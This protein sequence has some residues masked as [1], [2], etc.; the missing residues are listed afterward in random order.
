MYV[1]IWVP[2]PSVCRL[3]CACRRR[4]IFMTWRGRNSLLI[5]CRSTSCSDNSLHTSCYTA[6]EFQDVGLGMPSHDVFR[7]RVSSSKVVGAG[8]ERRTALFSLFQRCSMRFISGLCWSHIIV[9]T[10]TSWRYSTIVRAT[11]GHALSRIRRNASPIKYEN[12]IT[13]LSRMCST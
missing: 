3:T 2:L 5:S 11:C 12:G 8:W 7:T 6:D 13:C 4:P 9:C 10:S 1:H